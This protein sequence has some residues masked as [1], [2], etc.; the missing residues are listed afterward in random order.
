MKAYIAALLLL[1]SCACGENVKE[2]VSGNTANGYLENI[3]VP[4]AEKIQLNEE[5]T[6]RQKIIEG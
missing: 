4:T 6:L 3:G 1:T 2:S 5:H